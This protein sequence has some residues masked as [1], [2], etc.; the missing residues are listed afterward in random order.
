MYNA[1][2]Q[3]LDAPPQVAKRKLGQ[4]KDFGAYV[5][6]RYLPFLNEVDVDALTSKLVQEYGVNPEWVQTGNGAP[7]VTYSVAYGDKISQGEL[8]CKKVYFL[9]DHF[10]FCV[11]VLKVSDHLFLVY[12]KKWFLDLRGTNWGEFKQVVAGTADLSPESYFIPPSVLDDLYTGKLYPG[13]VAKL[14]GKWKSNWLADLERKDS[15]VSGAAFASQYGPDFF[16]F[17]NAYT[18]ESF[19]IP[20]D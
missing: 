7:F 19:H 20:S 12:P 3:I 8:S 14:F 10:H 13:R 18:N 6:Y 15:G 17:K 1:L 11:L 5:K 9:L 4:A 2:A 16:E